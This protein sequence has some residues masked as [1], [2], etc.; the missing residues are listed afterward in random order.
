[1]TGLATGPHLHFSVTK[2]GAFVDPSKLNVSRD[3]PVP[4]HAAYM[5]AIRPR[6][7]ALKAIP[8]NTVARN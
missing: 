8:S 7:A 2:N 4:D 6:I 1:M 3:A 5:D